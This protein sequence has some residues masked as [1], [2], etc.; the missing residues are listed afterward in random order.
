MQC[1]GLLQ[2][3]MHPVT[4]HTGILV[5]M[6]KYVQPDQ[7]ST[8]KMKKTL[9]CCCTS[10]VPNLFCLRTCFVIM[11]MREILHMN[12]H[13]TFACTNVSYRAENPDQSSKITFFNRMTLTFDLW[14]WPSNSS[15]RSSRSIPIPNL[16][17]VCQSV[18][19]WE[20]S[21]TDTHTHRQTDRPLR[22]YN[23]DRWRGR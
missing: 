7:Y 17:T 4:Q 15:E 16:V 23:L 13:E 8:T 22:F 19:P 9:K 2:H 6:L 5:S 21:Q 10:R 3:H 20:C 12:A 1:G 18:Q 11:H 14:P